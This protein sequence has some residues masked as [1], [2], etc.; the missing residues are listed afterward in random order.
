MMQSSRRFIA[1]VPTQSS[2]D[3]LYEDRDFIVFNK[4][5]GLLV[6]PTPKGEKSTLVNIVNREFRKKEETP[7]YPCHRIDRDTSGAIIFFLSLKCLDFYYFPG[8]RDQKIELSHADFG[9]AFI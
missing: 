2:I 4:P 5:T 3:V 8:D 1:K 6:V 7:L 9:I